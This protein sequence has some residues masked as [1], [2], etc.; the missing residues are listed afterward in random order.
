MILRHL[1][2]SAGL[3]QTD[4]Q[5][6]KTEDRKIEQQDRQTYLSRKALNFPEKNDISPISERPKFSILVLTLESR[7]EMFYSLLEEL[8]SQINKFDGQCEI[9]WE[10][11]SGEK[12]TGAK[13]NSLLNKANG[14]YLAFFDDDD[15][16][17]PTYV[18]DIL[19]AIKTNPDCCSL[20]GEITTDG[21]NPQIFEHSLKYKS[22]NTAQ[23]GR[24]KYERNPN[25]LNPIKSSI[26]KTVKFPEVNYGEDHAWS[27]AL[28]SLGLLKVEK[29]IQ[30][31]IYYYRFVT[32]K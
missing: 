20:L 16:P 29:E 27:M 28:H 10:S 26:A 2:P 14:E 19:E 15:W 1:H 6:E 5:Y 8:T 9:L 21:Q 11:D 31:V 32:K 25:H 24:V 17:S 3:A 4:A 12:T 22:W 18:S 23:T 30:N 7:R 13:R